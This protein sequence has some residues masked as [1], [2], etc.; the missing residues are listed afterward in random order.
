MTGRQPRDENWLSVAAAMSGRADCRRSQ[1]GAVIVDVNDRIAG[2][3]RN[4][5][6]SKQGSCLGGDCPRGLCTYAELPAGGSYS[7]CRGVHAEQNALIHGDPTR[8]RH[9]T[10]YVTREPCETCNLLLNGAGI[11]RVV[12]PGGEYGFGRL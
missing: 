4:G 1:V 8:F 2:H 10:V 9:A 12:W 6:P 11:A 5:I 3:G 7:N